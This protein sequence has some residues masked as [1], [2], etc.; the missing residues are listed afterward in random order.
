[1]SY[2]IILD[3][4]AFVSGLQSYTTVVQTTLAEQHAR[5]VEVLHRYHTNRIYT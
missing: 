5:Y 2:T 4:V 3:L 1:M